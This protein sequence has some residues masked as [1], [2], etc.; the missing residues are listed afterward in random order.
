MMYI[1]EAIAA[2]TEERPH[3]TREKWMNTFGNYI[4]PKLLPTNSPD[5]MVYDSR[6]QKE[7]RRGWQPTAEDLAAND[8][9]VIS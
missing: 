1:H 6:T 9:V 5:G 8:W 3:I 7:P 2:R 4:R